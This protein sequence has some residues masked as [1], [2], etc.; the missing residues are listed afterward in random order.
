[1]PQLEKA[2]T[3]QQRPSAA[4]NKSFF[5]T[6]QI[7]VIYIS[8][9]HLFYETQQSGSCVEMNQTRKFPFS[10]T[11]SVNSSHQNPGLPNEK[12]NKMKYQP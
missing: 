8:D 9:R 3:Q 11:I 7:S 5:K 2:L 1:M 4:I 6:F 10:M 12:Q